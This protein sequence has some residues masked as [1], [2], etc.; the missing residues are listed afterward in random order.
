M[1][2]KHGNWPSWTEATSCSTNSNL[3]KPL[4]SVRKREASWVL[5]RM[6]E[7]T[8]YVSLLPVSVNSR[9]SDNASSVLFLAVNRLPQSYVISKADLKTKCGWNPFEGMT[10]A[11]RV[12]RVVLRGQEVFKDG[13]IVA[14]AG[15]GQLLY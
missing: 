15:S 12:R 11:G 2:S 14:Q 5:S 9:T 8:R 1:P 3:A 13:E 10:V 6:K 4:V 7:A